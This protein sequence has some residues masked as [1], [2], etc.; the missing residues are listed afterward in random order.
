M[1][2]LTVAG[3]LLALAP[4]AGATLPLGSDIVT[5]AFRPQLVRVHTPAAA[6]KA[7]LNRLGLDLT[8]HAGADY[9]E[10]VLHRLADV[11]ALRAAL[12][13]WTVRIPDLVAREAENNRANAAFAA[14]T[15]VSPCRRGGTAT[16][17][18]PTTTAS[19]P[20]WPSGTRP[21]SSLWR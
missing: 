15:A 2:A 6:D 21:S 14:A 11:D 20:R 5:A 18:W 16:A 1:I 9:V 8:E 4:A 19:W 13:G 12:F 3:V 17:P 7:R 10:V